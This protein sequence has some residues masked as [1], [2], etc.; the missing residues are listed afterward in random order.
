MQLEILDLSNNNVLNENYL[1]GILSLSRLEI[2]NIQ[3]CI[4]IYIQQP[5]SSLQL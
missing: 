1:S 4:V 2:V 3:Y 5:F